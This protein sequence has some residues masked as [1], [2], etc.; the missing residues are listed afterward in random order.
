MSLNQIDEFAKRLGLKSLIL[1]ENTPLSFTLD[2][3]YLVSIE[4]SKGEEPFLIVSLAFNMGTYDHSLLSKALSLS[5]FES[6]RLLDF[7]VGYA[8]DQI[9]LISSIDLDFR[10]SELENIIL[11]LKKQLDVIRGV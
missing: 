6:I 2:E 1:T 8:K 11:N 9:I 3:K 5:S 4:Y 10:A 7:T